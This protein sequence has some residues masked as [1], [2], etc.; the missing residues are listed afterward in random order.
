[1]NRSNTIY[2]KF[3]S[4]KKKYSMNF[5]TTE[6]SICDI[7]KEI[8]RSRNMEKVPEKFEL[9]FYDE[10]ENEIRD[11]NYKVE[12]L[13]L[14]LI[15]RIPWYKLTTSFVEKVRDPSEISSLRFSDFGIV[16]RKVP[17]TQVN[18]IDPIEKIQSKLT[19]DSVRTAFGCNNCGKI[20]YDPIIL[21]CC[22]E[23]ICEECCKAKY[24]KGNKCLSC[25]EV[26]KGHM[27]NKKVKEFKERIIFIMNRQ[28]TQ[29]A[30]N[31]EIENKEAAAMNIQGKIS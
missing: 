3:K 29:L 20:E 21:L 9:I 30:I 24:Q 13:K 17:T 1:M 26:I 10:N 23:T 19:K 16:T 8:I 5:D 4:E 12:P 14:L 28:N 7:K 2:Y 31:S 22:G 27:L 15:K 25:G 18:F 11:E 6:I